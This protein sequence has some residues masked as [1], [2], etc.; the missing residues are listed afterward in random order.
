MNCILIMLSLRVFETSRRSCLTGSWLHGSE[1]LVKKLGLETQIRG[2]GHLV[3]S[4][5]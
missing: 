2:L 3:V 5:V 4:E 1:P